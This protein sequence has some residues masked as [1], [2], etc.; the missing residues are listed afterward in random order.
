MDPNLE[1]YRSILHLP[2]W[3]RRERMGHLP[4]SELDR[5]RAIIEREND[6]QRLEKSIAGRDLVQVALTDPSEIT[7]DTQ[8]QY[9]LLGRT[10][11]SRDEARM[12]KRITNNAADSS[13]SLVYQ[14]RHFDQ[15]AKHFCLDAWKL[16]YCDIYYVDGGSAT[17]QEIYEARLQEEELQTPAARARELV[18][19]DDLNQARRNAKWMIPAVERLSADEQVQL[20][21]EDEEFYQRLLEHSEDKEHTERFLKQYFY[22]KIPERIW[23][24]VSPAPPAW[25]QKILDTQEQWGFIYYLSREVDQKYVRN[26]KSTWNRLMNISSPLRVTWGSIHCQGGDNR[27]ALE[28][29]ETE[30]WPI[31]YP[32]ETMAEDD[33]LRKHF[34]EYIKE[35]RS[36]TQEDEKKKKNKKKYKKNKK[37]NDDLLSPGLLRNTFIVIPMEFIFGNRSR[38][39]GDFFDPCW[40]WAYDA[41]WDSSEEETV[42]NGEKYQGR[43]KVAKWSVNSWFY[44]ARWEGVSL[45]DMWLKA[46]QHPEKV[47]ICYTKR[48]EEWDHEPYI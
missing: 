38:E 42:F 28:R 17:L 23:K 11:Y 5:V 29:L 2:P 7:K 48:L 27:S 21:P 34:K 14:I 47:W 45:R 30:N 9:T 25:M 35:N 24:Q 33:D 15:S 46:Q 43:V 19:C 16:V 8:L 4:R 22:D 39:E 31:F 18:R 26:W 41:D 3:E 12:V 6:A 44:A 36:Q 40:V 20:A 37:E 13:S 1:L 10:I 32:N